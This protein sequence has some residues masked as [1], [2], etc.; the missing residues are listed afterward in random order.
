MVLGNFVFGSLAV[1]LKADVVIEL[2]GGLV[3]VILDDM[4]EDFD[5]RLEQVGFAGAVLAD[6]DIDKAAAV[7]AQGKIPKVFVLA[8]VER[9]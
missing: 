1:D 8:D 7:K 2:A 9:S 5:E 4:A 6:E 3:T